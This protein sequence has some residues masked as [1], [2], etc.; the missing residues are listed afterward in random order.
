[1]HIGIVN[2]I[3]EQMPGGLIK[4]KLNSVRVKKTQKKNKQLEALKP[5][6]WGW[7]HQIT[8]AGTSQ[9]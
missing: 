2:L 1:M 6:S 9:K 8:A 3:S 7:Q 5:P 4:L